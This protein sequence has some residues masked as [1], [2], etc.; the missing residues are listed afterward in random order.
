M[1]GSLDPD[2]EHTIANLA[3]V[4]AIPADGP[5]FLK[6][7]KAYIGHMGVIPDTWRSFGE[8]FL[9]IWNTP[10]FGRLI[11]KF[12]GRILGPSVTLRAVAHLL[13]LELTC[14]SPHPKVSHSTWRQ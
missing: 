6:S 12:P 11:A 9:R 13:L 2:E 14:G 3:A 10:N 1:L 5:L 7:Q 8:P 4:Q